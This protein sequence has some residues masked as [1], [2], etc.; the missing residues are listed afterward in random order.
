MTENPPIS[1]DAAPD[2]SKD[3]S[4]VVQGTAENLLNKLEE[5]LTQDSA[6]NE[7][8]PEDQLLQSSEPGPLDKDGKNVEDVLNIISQSIFREG[9]GHILLKLCDRSSLL[10]VVSHSLSAYITTLEPL[11]LQRLSARIA[12]EVSLWMCSLFHFQDGAAFCHDDT[13]EGLVRITRMALHKHYPKMCQDGFEALFS[14]PPVIYLTSGTYVEMGHYVCLQLGLPLSSIRVLRSDLDKEEAL[15]DIFNEDKAAGRL[16]IL[17]I[18][19]VH[20]SL[21]Q[22]STFILI[23]ILSKNHCRCA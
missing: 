3:L 2:V 9:E 11:P 4:Q 10:S 7:Q 8:L 17:C 22:V 14:R 13:R 15:E 6:K 5:N 20:S 19:N 23:M 12:S 21:F 1:Q 16:P 18:A